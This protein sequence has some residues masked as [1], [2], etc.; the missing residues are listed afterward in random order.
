M[1]VFSAAAVLS[2][3][4]VSMADSL[5]CETLTKP[6]VLDDLTP[7]SGKWIFLEGASDHQKYNSLLK[8]VNT[9]WMEFILP[10][11][12]DTGILNQGNMFNGKCNYSSENV[13]FTKNGIHFTT[14]DITVTGT[15]LP[16][17]TDCLLLM[18]TNYDSGD[19][20]KSLYLFVRVEMPSPREWETYKKQAECLGFKEAHFRYTGKQKLCPEEK[21]QSDIEGVKADQ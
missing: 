12:N 7:I 13:T 19:I 4:S 14:K 8:T 20:I 10:T 3:L 17:C 6:L 21:K 18:L 2:L 15:F 11:K 9:S 16:A 5:D 1:Y